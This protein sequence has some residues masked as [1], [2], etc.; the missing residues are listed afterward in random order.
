MFH[1]NKELIQHYVSHHRVD[2]NN[3]FF[4]KI[5]QLTNNMSI[6]R[7]CSR[8]DDFITTRD[9]KPKH[10]FLKH[11]DEGQNDL[12]EDKPLDITKLPFMIE[13]EI[14]IMKHGEYYS[15]FSAEEG[16][17]DFLKNVCSKFKPT[18]LKYFNGTFTIESIQA[19]AVKNLAPNLNSRFWATKVYRGVYFNDIVRFKKRYSKQSNP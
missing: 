7:K 3:T 12:H 10:D 4:Q 5:F 19:S 2:A 11:Y 17:E 14:S 18:V 15:F 13:F 1:N 6:L 9:Y 16:V 8:C